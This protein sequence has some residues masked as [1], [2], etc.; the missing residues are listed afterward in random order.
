MFRL[1]L[2]F[3]T[4]VVPRA[5]KRKQN[6]QR[7]MASQGSVITTTGLVENEFWS[8]LSMKSSPPASPIFHSAYAGQTRLGPAFGMGHPIKFWSSRLTLAKPTT[9]RILK[10]CCPL[11]PIHA[12]SGF[13]EN[14]YSW[15]TV[16]QNYPMPKH[17]SGYGQSGRKRLDYP[18]FI[19]L[20]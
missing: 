5:V 7:N 6:W 13:K 15:C 17:L 20:A 1:I 18:A 8:A 14:H 11:F 3:M 16:P 4:C 12:I 10:P 2:V 9:A 19:L